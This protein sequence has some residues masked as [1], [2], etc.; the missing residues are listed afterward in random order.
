MCETQP[1]RHGNIRGLVYEN[2]WKHLFGIW[3]KAG[4]VEQLDAD[5]RR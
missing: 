5:G 3:I 4:H 1:F 2:V